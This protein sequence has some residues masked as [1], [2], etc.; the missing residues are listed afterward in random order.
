MR[1]LDIFLI[2]VLV[3]LVIFYI[4]SIGHQ[5]SGNHRRNKGR[6]AMNFTIWKASVTERLM[7]HTREIGPAYSGPFGA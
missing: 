3:G 2:V 1:T 5:L 6:R 4:S 7:D